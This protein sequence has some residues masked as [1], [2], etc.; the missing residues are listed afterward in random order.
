MAGLMKFH[1]LNVK[2]PS[3]G[4]V[5]IHKSDLDKLNL[6]SSG[7]EFASEFLIKSHKIG[8]NV[9]E[10]PINYHNRLGESKL[11]TFKDGFRHL[12]FILF[13]I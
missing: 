3:T 7:M 12:N 5:A 1:G 13:G 6:Q 10:I 11:R 2:E 8:L 9:R 4:F